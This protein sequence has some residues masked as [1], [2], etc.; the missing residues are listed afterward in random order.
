[1]ATTKESLRLAA[2]LATGFHAATTSLR[3]RCG[4]LIW[5]DRNVTVEIAKIRAKQP[6][7][8]VPVKVRLFCPDCAKKLGL[9][10]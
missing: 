4:T 9:T 2:P 6:N 5:Q 7:P 8:A 3:C 1:M 10:G